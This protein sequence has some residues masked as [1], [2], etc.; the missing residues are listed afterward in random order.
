MQAVCDAHETAPREASVPGVTTGF[1][2]AWTDQV[3][4]SHCSANVM[5]VWDVSLRL[6]TAMQALLDAHDTALNP[7]GSTTTAFGACCIDQVA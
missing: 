7:P 4:P 1:A 6:P 2:V 3:M 5:V